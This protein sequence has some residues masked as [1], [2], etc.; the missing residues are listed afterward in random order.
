MSEVGGM[1]MVNGTY[2]SS[3]KDMG[4]PVA[5][6]DGYTHSYTAATYCQQSPT[7][8]V[9][10]VRRYVEYIKAASAQLRCTDGDD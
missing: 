9:S 10:G 2:N 1:D 8:V 5:A 6:R 7:V 4:R 3:I